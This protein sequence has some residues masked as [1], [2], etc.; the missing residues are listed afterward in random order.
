MKWENNRTIFE[1]LCCVC[2]VF[3]SKRIINSLNNGVEN[4]NSFCYIQQNR[5][6]DT[7]LIDL[8]KLE[9]K[10]ESLTRQSHINSALKFNSWLFTYNLSLSHLTKIVN[11]HF[12]VFFS[13]L[14]GNQFYRKN[15]CLHCA[16]YLHI[17]A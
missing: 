14:F 8:N 7:V 16:T 15:Y 5:F 10:S 17:I 4:F 6:M 13:F 11:F 9:T 1:S 3:P 12:S 2:N